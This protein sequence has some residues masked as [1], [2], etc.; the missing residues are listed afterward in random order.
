[1]LAGSSGAGAGSA[2]MGSGA[3]V[4]LPKLGK[5]PKLP[6]PASPSANRMAA[7]GAGP[8]LSLLMAYLPSSRPEPRARPDPADPTGAQ[9]PGRKSS[10]PTRQSARNCISVKV[11]G[12]QPF[13]SQQRILIG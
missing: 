5:P 10:D 3:G 8:K 6:Q 2:G 12:R 1:M 11:N 13:C 9:L 4:E 7:A